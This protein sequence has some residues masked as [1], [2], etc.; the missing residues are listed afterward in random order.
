[1]GHHHHAPAS[2][3]GRY[4]RCMSAVV[5][6]G[7]CFMAVEVVV[8]LVTGS[9][10]LL[11]D[12]AHMF[13]DVFGLGVALVA[14]VLARRSA[15]T[16]TRTFGMYR[17]EVFSA[18]LNAVLLTGIA[19]FVLVEAVLRLHDPPAVPGLPMTLTAAAGVVANVASVL[20]LHSGSRES[21]NVRGAY[22]E[23]VSDLVGS[24][25]VLVAG[26]VTLLTGWRYA[27][28]LV[29][30]AIAVFVL[31]RVYTLGR[32]SLRIL[33]QHAPVAV[34]VDGI[35]RQL[36][37]LDGVRDVHDLHV[38]TLTSGMDVAS[39]HLAV[40]DDADDAGVLHAAQHVLAADHDIEHATLQVE[41]HAAQLRCREL[42]W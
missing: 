7:A 9:L 12:A 23:V 29:G 31:P 27:D 20:L 8:G 35:A 26:A 33:L 2:A 38:W 10:A 3:S 42:S 24:V 21:L 6:I 16:S 34:D 32:Q 17:G 18:L 11:S 5:A 15:P 36:E 25:G 39:A 28:P 13:T 1:M 41:K 30:V 19:V 37:D 22:L 4:L 14:I 40:D